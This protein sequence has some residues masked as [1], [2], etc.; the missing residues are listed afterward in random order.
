MRRSFRVTLESRHP[1]RIDLCFSGRR[2]AVMTSA[3]GLRGTLLVEQLF[4]LRQT[5]CGV[6]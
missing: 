1:R 4:E 6:G 5:F 2:R 3:S